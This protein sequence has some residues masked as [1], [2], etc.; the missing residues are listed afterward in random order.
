MHSNGRRQHSII[1]DSAN[2]MAAD[3]TVPTSRFFDRMATAI[4]KSRET[5]AIRLVAR[6]GL[7]PGRHNDLAERMVRTAVLSKPRHGIQFFA[8][9]LEADVKKRNPNSTHG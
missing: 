1:S 5:S 8:D 7:T 3:V 9:S 6:L 2:G 4:N